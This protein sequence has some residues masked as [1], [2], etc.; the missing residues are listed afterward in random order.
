MTYYMV[1]TCIAYLFL[2][3]GKPTTLTFD[4]PIEFLV[5]SDQEKVEVSLSKSKKILVL[6]PLVKLEEFPM[7]AVTQKGNFQFRGRFNKG[8]F[9]HQLVS[10]KQ[11][12][13]DTRFNNV[14]SGVNFK[15]LEGEKSVKVINSKGKDLEV[16]SI[17]SKKDQFVCKG[18]PLFVNKKEIRW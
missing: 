7:V 1:S 14:Y 11:G 8:S 5:V 16:N 10:I 9:Y 2:S 15:V 3:A 18:S 6:K 13:E 12:K 4:S 17:S